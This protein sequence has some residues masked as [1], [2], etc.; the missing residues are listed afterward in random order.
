M[1]A[2]RQKSLFL[3]V[4]SL[5]ERMSVESVINLGEKGV[6][7]VG[8]G[9]TGCLLALALRK[10]G[11]AVTLFE[12]RPDPRLAQ[13]QGRSINL[14]MTSRGIN[15]LTKISDS[16]AERVMKITVPVFGRELHS[17]SGDLTYQPYG[18]TASH[19]NFS[20][21][22][23]ELNT[24]LL[25]AAEEEGC[26][27]YFSHPLTHVDIPQKT[28]Y[29]YLQDP[30]TTRLYQKSVKCGHI[31]GADGGGSRCRQAL[32]GF[33]GS[34][35]SDKALPLRYGYKELYMPR[36]SPSAKMDPM[37]LHI[38][39]RG[40]HFLMALPNKDYSYY[41]TLYMP[42]KGDLSFE[43]LKSPESV[44]AYFLKYYPDAVSLMPD[45]ENT[46]LTIPTVFLGLFSLRHG[47]MKIM[48]LSLEML[49]TL[50]LHFL[51]K[52]VIVA[53]KISRN[54]SLSSRNPLLLRSKSYLRNMIAQ[55]NQTEMQLPIW[56]LKIFMK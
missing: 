46:S 35:S 14:V 52:V 24:V 2:F 41:M 17:V 13:D 55:E 7:V 34:S 6:A 23:W 45:F 3:F 49:L 8:A 47:F 28:L 20:V 37:A 18:P 19:C 51:D 48:L 10:F 53:S 9:L 32:K 40:T 16:L 26:K 29:F 33:L 39:P 43:S 36:P 50:S 22:R 56:P 15:S 30:E 25:S 27:V 21:S 1:L 12:S 54:S 4:F 44:R 31:F 42:E 11:L 5:F 38:W